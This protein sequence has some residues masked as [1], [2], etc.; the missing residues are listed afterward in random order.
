MGIRDL[1]KQ[2]CKGAL[3]SI[4][5][6]C[7]NSSLHGEQMFIKSE[8]FAPCKGEGRCAKDCKCNGYAVFVSKEDPTLPEN[9]GG[10]FRAGAFKLCLS[11]L[12]A[13]DQDAE[14]EIEEPRQERVV[15]E[16]EI[17]PNSEPSQ[18]DSDVVTWEMLARVAV[19]AQAASGN[20]SPVDELVRLARRLKSESE[21]TKSKLITVQERL[22]EVQSAALAEIL[23]PVSQVEFVD[24][25]EPLGD[26]EAGETLQ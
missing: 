12:A 10:A 9:Q 7:R 8:E 3:V 4:R 14:T 15:V 22:L 5:D 17:L 25:Q 2:L 11:H 20:I 1:R 18:V 24:L 16:V 13:V 23:E 21:I 19:S 6:T 26:V